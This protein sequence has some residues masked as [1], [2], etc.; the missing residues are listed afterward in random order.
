MEIDETQVLKGLLLVGTGTKQGA[1]S[2][3][4]QSL[5]G[6]GHYRKFW[7]LFGSDSPHS[8][9]YIYVDHQSG[10]HSYKILKIMARV[11]KNYGKDEALKNACDI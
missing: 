10:R 9:P 4:K 3:L 11:V 2:P 1:Q 5:R 8:L 7:L 6:L